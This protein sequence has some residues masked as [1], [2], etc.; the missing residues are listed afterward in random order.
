MI[1]LLL[2]GSVGMTIILT[3][4]NITEPLRSALP[5]PV[6]FSGLKPG[7]KTPL[8]GCPLCTGTWVGWAVGAY[9]YSQDILPCTPTQIPTVI[10]FGFAVAVAS[11]FAGV[12]F[13][14]NDVPLKEK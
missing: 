4:A 12:W 5:A 6:G 7:A 8:L 13:H 11:Y 9:A 2:L 1:W 10:L 14:H 3:M